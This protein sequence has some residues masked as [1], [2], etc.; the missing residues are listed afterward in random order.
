MPERSL[1]EIIKRVQDL[2]RL[3]L[4]ADENGAYC[5][6]VAMREIDCLLNH[7]E[8]PSPE[9]IVSDYRRLGFISN[10]TGGLTPKTLLQNTDRYSR[11]LG[12]NMVGVI[13][14]PSFL[15]KL[16]I[17]QHMEGTVKT[18][19]GIHD[20]RAPFMQIMLWRENEDDTWS[21]HAEMNDGSERIERRLKQLADEGWHTAAVIQFEQY[22]TTEPKTTNNFSPWVGHSG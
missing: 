2:E 13:A 17:P 1:S 6:L 18:A 7:S 16:D 4:W 5:G 12:L 20:I 8:V 19:T 11:E 14:N 9:D 21:A 15:D 3:R 10:L 22:N